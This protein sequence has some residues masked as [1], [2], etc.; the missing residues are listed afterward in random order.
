MPGILPVTR[1]MLKTQE[2]SQWQ[3]ILRL[4]ATQQHPC[5]FLAVLIEVEPGSARRPSPPL[6]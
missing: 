4:T 2:K 5:H 1:N 6:S 3:N